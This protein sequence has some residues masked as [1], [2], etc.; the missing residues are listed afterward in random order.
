M[1]CDTEV[2][3]AP[4]RRSGTA[5]CTGVDGSVDG[6]GGGACARAAFGRSAWSRPP[7]A[8]RPTPASSLP[9]AC[10]TSTGCSRTA[11]QLT[12][13]SPR[14]RRSSSPRSTATSWSR[15]C[16][17]SR[18]SARGRPPAAPRSTSASGL[19]R[20]PLACSPSPSRGT[21]RP[22]LA[23]PL[24]PGV[25]VAHSHTLAPSHP[26]PRPGPRARTLSLASSGTLALAPPLAPRP[27]A[28][29]H[30]HP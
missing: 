29:Q 13:R 4:R 10:G 15:G 18:R 1:S 8:P 12:E 21:V 7:T 30:P 14:S 6:S 2:A 28:P 17:R 16:S 11:S 5:T 27:F 9:S 26:H 20:R 23:R 25:S 24:W 22:S 19:P 3:V